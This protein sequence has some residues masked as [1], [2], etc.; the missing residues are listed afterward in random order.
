MIEISQHILDLLENSI[1]AG[2]S[3]I[4]LTIRVDM[5]QNFLWIIVEDNGPG[6]PEH[7]EEEI[8]TPFFT[9][10]REKKTGL[11]LSLAKQAVEQ[12]GGM[13]KIG[14]SETLGGAKVEMGFVYSHIDR[15]PMGDLGSAIA[16]MVF[17]CPNIK[18]V[19]RIF[20]E[21]KILLEVESEVFREK[22]K[23]EFE[24]SQEIEKKING[25]IRALNF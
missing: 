17:T 11:G 19:V 20:K 9:T 6:F 21:D 4:H 13:L 18:L 15:A 2:A 12:T 22:Y 8:L 23:D 25:C 5:I 24:I 10:K 16:G 1:N 7:T 14:T 3:E